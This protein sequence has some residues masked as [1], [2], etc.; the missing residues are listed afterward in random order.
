MKPIKLK[1]TE[2]I[3]PLLLINAIS[4]VFFSIS[5]GYFWLTWAF[6]NVMTLIY[7]LTIFITIDN[8]IDL[9]NT[10]L[11]A[12]KLNFENAANPLVT[13]A[14]CYAYYLHKSTCHLYDGKDYANTHL[15][16]VVNIV[17]DII[18]EAREAGYALSNDDV[19]VIIAAAWC[20]DTIEDTR[21]S[22]NDI[23]AIL[24]ERVADIVYALS[25]DKGKTRKD[26]AGAKYYS[27]MLL[28]TW[29]PLVKYADRLANIEY[30][31]KNKSR[32]AKMYIDDFQD[33]DSKLCTGVPDIIHRTIRKKFVSITK[34]YNG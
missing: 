23:K 17:K 27:D 7:G 11:N 13:R 21:I 5:D 8:K 6:A 9:F 22:Y 25:N 29:A 31:V 2:I 24:G 10:E 16:H 28:V 34:K 30:S 14:K 26:R 32:M 4:I 3:I 33:F 18:R 20:H 12:F 19:D 1:L 15:T